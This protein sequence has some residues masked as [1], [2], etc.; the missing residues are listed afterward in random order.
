M[1]KRFKTDD[2]DL[3]N[4]LKQPWIR[5]RYE[6]F[7]LVATLTNISVI[8]SDI[9]TSEKEIYNSLLGRQLSKDASIDENTY[10]AIVLPSKPAFFTG[11]TFEGTIVLGRYDASLKPDKVVINGKEIKD[12]ENG[13]ALVKFEAGKV[14]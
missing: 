5:N 1:N 11:E 2:V 4:G 14:G 7:P 13:A 6:G 10:K 9:K 8:Q 12:R 3:E